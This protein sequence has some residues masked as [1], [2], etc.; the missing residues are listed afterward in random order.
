MT[1]PRLLT[2]ATLSALFVWLFAPA[3]VGRAS[4][5]YRD[6][7]H[8]YHPLFEY[9]RAE[10]GAGRVPLWNPYENL[11]LPLAGDTTASLFYPGKLLF[12][13][14]LDYTLLY[15]W[16]L[17]G[18]VALAAATSYALA[19][20][21]GASVLAAGLAAVSYAFSGNVLFQYCNVVFLVGAAWLPLAVLAANRMLMGQS[22]RAALGLGAVWALMTTG[23][24]PQ[25]AYNAGLIAML[26]AVVYWRSARQDEALREDETLRKGESLPRGDAFREGE[27]P[28]EPGSTPASFSLIGAAALLTVAAAV[29]LL[30]AAVQILPSWEAARRS[31][32]AS[33][34]APRNVYELADSLFEPQAPDVEPSIPWYAGLLGA[35]GDV[36]ERQIYQFNVGPWRAAETLWP[37]ISG[38]QFPRHRRWLDALPADG[39]VWTPSL[40]MGLLPLVLAIA[41]F[42]LRRSTPP[43][44]RWL[45]WIV[46]L[47][48]LAGC[49]AFGAV[50][51]AREVAVWCGTSL[52]GAPGDEVGGL[53][54]LMTVLLPGYVYFRYPAKLLVLAALGLS[55]LAARGWDTSW[56]QPSR[57]LRHGLTILAAASGFGLCA[58]F[59]CRSM[60]LAQFT[61]IPANVMFGP[62][63]AAGAFRD[64]ASA[65]AQAG[66]VAA[67]LLLL[68]ARRVREALGP[69]A[70]IGGL[71]L[72]AVDLAVAQSW[73]VQLAPAEAWRG[74]PALIAS[75]PLDLSSY[76]IYRDEPWLPRA[77]RETSSD[78][79]LRA[80]LAW[81]RGTLAPRY[82]LPL[83]ASLVAAAASIASQDYRSF[84]NAARR[85]PPG[86]PPPARPHPSVL[87]LLGV[88]VGLLSAEKG[89]PSPDSGPFAGDDLATARRPFAL[90]RA[91][92]VHQVE[93]LPEL[94]SHAP[95]AVE[96]RTIEVLFPGGRPR[97]WSHVAVVESDAPL[98]VTPQPPF[99]AQES[100]RVVSD[101]PGRV[102]IEATLNAPGLVV[103]A[104]TFYPGWTLSVETGQTARDVPIVR[105]NRVLRGAALPAGKHRLVYRYQPASV[106]WGAAVSAAALAGWCVALIVSRVR[107]RSD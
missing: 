49:G 106:R 47:S 14:P 45:S 19:R 18:H 13:L 12:A 8:F 40:Y 35:S 102:E 80:A 101:E 26:G 21:F 34:D 58:V 98:D 46:V 91:W 25:M 59:A 51:L 89:A 38:R 81:D 7:A 62:I 57:R 55:M 70:V 28:A 73:L 88:R 1:R 5:A 20:H 41:G 107:R 69:W 31:V 82:P 83:H 99:H 9:A 53:Y 22:W 6:A 103:L 105:T 48:A 65:F 10:W 63:D 74:R 43:Y 11:G 79:R 56:R 4:F 2:L 68:M 37:N 23:G 72:S 104:D 100:C 90:P 61:E 84:M 64:L 52:G 76:R 86:Q 24:D 97:D 27:T 36:Q 29:G 3:L 75:L 39:R 94:T 66:I 93:R 16:Y 60:L 92:I 54:W 44:V 87:N 96:R 17:V 15:N 71:L 50:W 33:Y 95:L 30:L 77:W 85:S 42:S 32:R 67:I 78:D